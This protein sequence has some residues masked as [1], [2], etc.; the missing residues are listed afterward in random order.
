MKKI[1]SIAVAGAT[2]LSLVACGGSTASDISVSDTWEACTSSV[3]EYA[4]GM[5]LDAMMLNDIYGIDESLV[6]EFIVTIPMMSAQIDETAI[7]KAADGKISE[8]EAKV[9][10]RAEALKASAFYPEHVELA[11]DAKISV[12]GDYIFFSVGNN[13][14]AFLDTFN[15]QF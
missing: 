7:I 6:E 10:E 8:V 11:Q 12:K 9:A 14:Q 5:E 2:L 13:A 1:L 15:A 4:Q 3:E